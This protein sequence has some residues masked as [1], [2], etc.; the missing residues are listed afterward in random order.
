MLS[1]FPD[2]GSKA[3]PSRAVQMPGRNA[4][5]RRNPCAGS[6]FLR[7]TGDTGATSLKFQDKIL[8]HL[9]IW[10]VIQVIQAAVRTPMRRASSG[11]E[12]EGE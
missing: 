8:Y 2:S 9:E 7:A 10:Q 12:F 4:P 1:A 11:Y 6:S 3:A 5:V